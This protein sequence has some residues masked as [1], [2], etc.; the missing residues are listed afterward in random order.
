MR[1]FEGTASLLREI[2][3]KINE[4]GDY[5]LIPALDRAFAMLALEAGVDERVLRAPC[6]AEIVVMEERRVQRALRGG[7]ITRET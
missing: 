7:L 2:E 4:Q 1:Y 6:S 5:D 3:R